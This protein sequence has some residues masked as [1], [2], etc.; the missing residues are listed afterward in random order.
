V[1]MKIFLTQCL[2]QDHACRTAVATAKA[3]GWL[4]PSASPDTAAPVMPGPLGDSP[5]Q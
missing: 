5:K 2:S 3:R 4:P 1:T